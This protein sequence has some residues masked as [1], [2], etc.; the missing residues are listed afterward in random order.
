MLFERKTSTLLGSDLFS[1]G[2]ANP[3]PYQEMAAPL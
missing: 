2:A 1:E 3:T